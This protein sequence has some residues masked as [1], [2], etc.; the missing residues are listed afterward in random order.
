VIAATGAEG[1]ENGN[2]SFVSNVNGNVINSADLRAFYSQVYLTFLRRDVD[3]VTSSRFTED[4]TYYPHFSYSGNI[5]TNNQVFRYYA[6][7]IA[8]D[9]IKAYLGADFTRTANNWTFNANGIGYINPDRDYFSHLQASVARLIP[10]GRES[11]LSLFS[12][13]R[14]AFD[15]M[16]NPL[17]EPIDNYVSVG[18]RANLGPVSIGLTQYFDGILPDSIE[19]ALGVDAAV[20]LGSRGTLRGYYSPSNNQASYGAAAE[21][22]FGPNY[23]SPTLSI[24]WRRDEYDFGS[25]ASNNPLRTEGN[26]FTVMFRVG[27]PR[28]PFRPRQQS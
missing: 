27:A 2:T 25:D 22:R 4:T 3:L 9:P 23:N 10:L 1:G 17:D 26:T 14:Y 16:S 19:T 5:T 12:G 21:L 28:E 8:A 24:G 6:G 7:V 20:R 13:M 11:N 18:A 15:T